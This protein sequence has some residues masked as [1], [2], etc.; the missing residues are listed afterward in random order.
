MVLIICKFLENKTSQQSLV[1]KKLLEVS[2]TF[3]HDDSKGLLI[4]LLVVAIFYK[5]YCMHGFSILYL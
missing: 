1:Y 4:I 5:Q 2:L 3:W